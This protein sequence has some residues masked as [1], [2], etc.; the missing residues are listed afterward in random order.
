MSTIYFFLDPALIKVVAAF[1]DEIK[2]IN[3]AKTA[4][5]VVESRI[6]DRRG[7][8]DWRLL[9][10]GRKI[11]LDDY[12]EESEWTIPHVGNED[13]PPNESEMYQ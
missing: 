1:T 7:D 8:T 11:V 5:H 10:V 9:L 13:M 2:A 4:G 6:Y 3:F 12:S